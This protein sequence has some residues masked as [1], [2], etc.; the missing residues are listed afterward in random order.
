MI[1]GHQAAKPRLGV[2]EMKIKEAFSAIAEE[3][4]AMPT[5]AAM[6]LPEQYLAPEVEQLTH[7]GAEIYGAS[8]SEL[9]SIIETC[10]ASL[11]MRL[12][13]GLFLGLL[14]D[15]RIRGADPEMID[16]AGG[17]VRIGLPLK[18]VSVVA[19]RYKERGVKQEWIAKE[20]P[21]HVVRLDPYRIGKY[22]VTNIEFA[23]FLR[24]TWYPEVPTSWAFGRFNPALSNHPVYSVSDTAA[25]AYAEWLSRTT[26]RS[27]RLPRE[28]EWEYAAAGPDGRAFPWGEFAEDCANTLESGLLMTTPVGCF[29]KGSSFFG[30]LDMAGNV[31]EWTSDFY[32]AYPGGTTIGDDL[33]TLAAARN[34]RVCRGGAFTRFQDLARCQRRH[35]PVGLPLYPISFR[36]AEDI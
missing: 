6:G 29:P 16:I 23:T 24:E 36:L 27:F 14:G 33:A 13:A 1:V 3:I 18:L 28:S 17:E 2:V 4:N 19:D 20:A 7:V 30:G 25:M 31:E 10:E 15:P 34:Y 22:L 35:G 8:P 12:A 9:I 11:E 32:A 21:R 5:R 26:R